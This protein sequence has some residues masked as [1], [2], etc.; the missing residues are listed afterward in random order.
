M[1]PRQI[2]LTGLAG[3]AAEEM[4]QIA[5]ADLLKNVDDPS[6]PW[7]ARRRVTLT[8]DLV[9]DESRRDGSIVVGCTTKMP[10]A[11]PTSVKVHLGRHQ[12]TLAAVEAMRQEEL[13]PDSEAR[14]RP[15]EVTQA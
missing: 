2:T 13:F 8:F 11:K 4:F 7:K 3:G 15:V 6:M 9:V 1:E 14:P 10:E 5:F 12:G